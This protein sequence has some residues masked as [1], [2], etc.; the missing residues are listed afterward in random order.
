MPRSVLIRTLEV[1]IDLSID[2]KVF[3]WL[4]RTCNIN[5]SLGF[6]Q[7]LVMKISTKN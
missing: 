4:N 7:F 5:V 3:V 2:A 6:I 1:K